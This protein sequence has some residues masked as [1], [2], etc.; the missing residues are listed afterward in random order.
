[1]TINTKN[2]KIVLII[3][4]LKGKGDEAKELASGEAFLRLSEAYRIL[5]DEVERKRYDA[6][7][8]QRKNTEEQVRF[9]LTF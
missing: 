1:M 5:D 9:M 2:K 7:R 8:E 3:T 4:Y 6:F